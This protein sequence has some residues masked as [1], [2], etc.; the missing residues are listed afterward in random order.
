MRSEHWAYIH[1]HTSAW[2]I[3]Y[4]HAL[5]DGLIVHGQSST[6]TKK[7]MDIIA[8]RFWTFKRMNTYHK[9]EILAHG[10]LSTCDRHIRAKAEKAHF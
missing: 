10:R 3:E 6:W 9:H 7:S 1:E 5:V 2:I 8:Q 4:E